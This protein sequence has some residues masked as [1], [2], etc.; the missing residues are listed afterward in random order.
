MITGGGRVRTA[1]SLVLQDA[2]DRRRIA[3]IRIKSSPSR[4]EEHV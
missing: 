4:L 1:A 2:A 3:L